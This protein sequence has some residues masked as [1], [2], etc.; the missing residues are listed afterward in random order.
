MGAIMGWC[1]VLFWMSAIFVLSSILSL[2]IPVVPLPAFLLKTLAHI[3]EYAMLTALLWWVLQRYSG[4]RIPAWLLAILIA[5]M[6]A[7][8]EEWYQSWLAGYQSAIRDVGDVGIDVL[9]IAVC[10][11]LAHHLS[12]PSSAIF[13]RMTF[14]RAMP[15]MSGHMGVSLATLGTLGVALTSH[16]I[17]TL[18]L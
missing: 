1:V 9:G 3:A 16:P 10:Y 12:F 5:G 15:N 14:N 11:T 13:E 18:P 8:S 2:H 17:G 7:F 4:R 6:Y